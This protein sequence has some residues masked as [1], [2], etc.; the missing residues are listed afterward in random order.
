MCVMERVL[1]SEHFAWGLNLHARMVGQ[2]D[3]CWSMDTR[4]FSFGSILVA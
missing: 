3:H 4:D 1:A 2:L